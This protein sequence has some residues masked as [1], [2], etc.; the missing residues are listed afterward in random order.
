MVIKQRTTPKN[1]LSQKVI[2]ISDSNKVAT[3]VNALL[4]RKYEKEIE[5]NDHKQKEFLEEQKRLV[6]FYRKCISDNQA[7]QQRANFK[8]IKNKQLERRTKYK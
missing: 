4:R 5:K 2:N 3:V 8:V 7:L 1:I 6:I